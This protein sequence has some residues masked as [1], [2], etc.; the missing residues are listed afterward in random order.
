MEITCLFLMCLL[1]EHRK[2]AC[3]HKFWKKFLGVLDCSKIFLT[4][5]VKKSFSFYIL[6][7]DLLIGF[8]AICPSKMTPKTHVNAIII[9]IMKKVA[10]IKQWE[11]LILTDTSVCSWHYTVL[12]I[13]KQEKSF[14]TVIISTF[15]FKIW[16]T[17]F[18]PV[19]DWFPWKWKM[20]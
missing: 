18:L 15:L 14:K 9:V 1:R 7:Y 5:S 16:S 19:G 8:I 12:S 10:T 17:L 2:G 13:L 11:L 4:K 6:L 3:D 20:E